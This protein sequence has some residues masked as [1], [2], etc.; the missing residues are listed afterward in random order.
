[1]P[2]EENVTPQ[3]EP[4]AAEAAAD[5]APDTDPHPRVS[6][7]RQVAAAQLPTEAH[8]VPSPPIPG[9]A[10]A[11]AD[12]AAR[13]EGGRDQGE[14]PTK[15]TRLA[16]Q[17]RPA[18]ASK[19][20]KEERPKPERGKP[21][22]SKKLGGPKRAP[23][24]QLTTDPAAG[25]SSPYKVASA[26]GTATLPTQVHPQARNVLR[27]MMESPAPPTT[28]FSIVDRLVGSPY[29]N[30][31]GPTAEEEEEALAERAREVLL[32]TLDLA[33]TMMRWGAGA[34]EVETSVIAATTSL[35]LRHIDLDVTNQSVHL[36]YAPPEGTPASILRVVRSSTDNFAGLTLIHQL[37]ADLSAGRVG[38]DFARQRLRSI[39]RRPKPY[40]P[41]MVLIAGALFAGLFVLVI[42]G[43]F[44]GALAALV[45]SLVATAVARLGDRWRVPGFFSV[46]ASMAVVTLVALLLFAVDWL[47]SPELVVAG[48]MMLVL[49][50][51]RFVSAV[52]DAIYGFPITAIGRLFSALIVYAAII[53]GVMVGAVVGNTLGMPQL[54]LARQPPPSSLSFPL[55]CVLVVIAVAL[56]GVV[57][58]T[59][60]RLLWV[61]S[62][63][64]LIGYLF[65][66]FAQHQLGTG[67][68]LTPALAAVIMGLLARWWGLKLGTTGLVLAVP[69]IVILLPG[70][71]IFRAMYGVAIDTDDL[72]RGLAAMVN[73]FSIIMGIAAGVALGDTLARPFT[74]DWNA[75]VRKRIRRR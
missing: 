37:V 14:P 30:T 2:P 62:L 15:P 9:H 70:L 58:Q 36:N 33:E 27:R 5:R 21:T 52:Q 26:S 47:H 16:R 50:S 75:R 42:G 19:Q 25:P 28:S 34:L 39:R 51:G 20:A 44:N 43:T 13:K 17:G 56:G 71:A 55:L 65:V 23:E 64:A 7:L 10:H 38:L 73:A 3:Q 61:T 8:D 68:R 11:D 31:K 67:P 63:I 59:A 49:P 72:A 45:S 41:W 6:L 4:D 18:R 48:G 57:Q 35:G 60:P 40:P 12:A 24:R 69:A 46:A 32:F 53:A 74:K 29:A 54:D 22:G 1:M 66:A